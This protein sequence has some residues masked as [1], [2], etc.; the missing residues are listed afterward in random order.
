M[1]RSKVLHKLRN[2]RFAEGR[3]EAERARQLDPV[4]LIINNLIG[5]VSMYAREYPRALDALCNHLLRQQLL[6][7]PH[8]LP[9]GTEPAVI[10]HAV[11][12]DRAAET[13]PIG[14][15]QRT[16]ERQMDAEERLGDPLLF[17]Q[18]NKG[19]QKR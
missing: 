14:F 8:L 7:L 18:G 12:N 4:S 10:I 15:R 19:T 9:V 1:R 6:F 16:P 5:V 3:A 13:P 17:A 2:G 11:V